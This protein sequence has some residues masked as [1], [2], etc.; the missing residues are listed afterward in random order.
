[1]VNIPKAVLRGFNVFYGSYRVNI[2]NI[3]SCNRPQS[4]QKGGPY[5]FLMVA[6][7]EV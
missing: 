5:P 4:F 6:I 7:G 1:M 2:G 3:G